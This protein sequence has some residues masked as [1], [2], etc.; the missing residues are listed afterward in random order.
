MNKALWSS[1]VIALAAGCDSNPNEVAL[2]QFG[3]RSADT[4]CDKVYQCCS[5]TDAE[6]TA[7]MG[8]GGG[9]AACG[10]KN[11]DSMGF[12]AAVMA[13]E[14]EKGRL[15]Y[16]P[17]LAHRCLQAFAAA[18]CDGHKRNVVLE[19]CDTFITPKTPAGAPCN[20]SESCIAGSCV[21][22]SADKEGVCQ[23]FATE[24]TSCAERTCAKGLRCEGAGKLCV[25][26]RPNGETCQTN[27]ECQSQGCN[28]RNPDA[29]TPGTC[30]LKGGADTTCFVTTGCSFGGRSDGGALPL[31]L[32][33][34]LTVSRVFAG[35]F[36]A[37]R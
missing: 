19:G 18:S 32:L 15:A 16:D 21:D 27:V 4:V 5:L 8:Y 17:K 14:Q 6:L 22:G 3:Q 33:F 37:K 23:A 24:N 11:R 1:I 30:G 26:A 12:W 9:R 29:G 31:V 34:V 10:S 36:R 7:H 13:K 2:A 25:P 20:A 28:G 35:K